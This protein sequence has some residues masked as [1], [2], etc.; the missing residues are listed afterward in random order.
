MYNGVQC[1]NPIISYIY[2][3]DVSIYAHVC[4][5]VGIDGLEKKT[6]SSYIPSSTASSST[7]SS[8]SVGGGSSGIGGAVIGNDRTH[9]GSGGGGGGGGGTGDDKT[10]KDKGKLSKAN[11]KE[12]VWKYLFCFAGK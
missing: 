12:N 8:L 1:A 11:I 6:I 10:E 4:I 9:S 3:Y 7:P 5:C 2:I